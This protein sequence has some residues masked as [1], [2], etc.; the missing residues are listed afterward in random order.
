MFRIWSGPEGSSHKEPLSGIRIHRAHGLSFCA[1]LPNR[2][3][4]DAA[5]QDINGYVV[6]ETA[7][8]PSVFTS[9]D[10]RFSGFGWGNGPLC[11]WACRLVGAICSG[12][13]FEFLMR[14]V[15]AVVIPSPA[16]VIPA[17][18]I[19]LGAVSPVFASLPVV[20]FACLPLLEFACL[21]EL[22]RVSLPVAGELTGGAVSAGALSRREALSRSVSLSRARWPCLPRPLPLRMLCRRRHRPLAPFP[23]RRGAYLAWLH[24]HRC[25]LWLSPPH[26]R[27]TEPL[28]PG[29]RAGVGSGEDH[30]HKIFLAFLPT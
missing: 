13:Y 26:F 27:N 30:L 19:A 5:R 14:R 15:A 22:G 29:F 25:G 21:V 17:S 6:Q 16:A 9:K 24:P 10:A 7:A 20:V 2:A 12:S 3:M 8:L 11:L 28:F 18:V 1:V 4:L 23:N